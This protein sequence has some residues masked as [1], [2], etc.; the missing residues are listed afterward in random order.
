MVCTGEDDVGGDDGGLDDI[1][2]D[3]SCGVVAVVDEGEVNDVNSSKE[4][5]S[6]PA[7]AQ[8]PRRLKMLGAPQSPPYAGSRWPCARPADP[9]GT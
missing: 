6:G 8:H 2:D 3:Q 1:V 7:K 5:C 9:R 4:G